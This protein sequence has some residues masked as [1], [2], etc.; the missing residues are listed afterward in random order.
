MDDMD[1]DAFDAIAEDPVVAAKEIRKDNSKLW[2]GFHEKLYFNLARAYAVADEMLTNKEAWKNFIEDKWWVDHRKKRP[3]MKDRSEPLLHVMVFIF[4]H[5]TYDRAWNYAKALEKHFRDRTPPH[6][7]E[8]IIKQE[9]GIEK[10]VRAASAE[11]ENH[12]K[13][14]PKPKKAVAKNADGR[15]DTKNP[16][17]RKPNVMNEGAIVKRPKKDVGARGPREYVFPA[18]KNFDPEIQKMITGQKARITIKLVELDG[19]RSPTMIDMQRLK[20]LRA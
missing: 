19:Q 15:D 10:M 18:T 3:G 17:P 12:G 2:K 9:G 7:I 1:N 4:S 11:H 20:P 13:S 8:A 6:C 5:G 14:V 16:A